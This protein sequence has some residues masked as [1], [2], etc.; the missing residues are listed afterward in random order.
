MIDPD[1][2]YP[3]QF[4]GHV[5]VTLKD[6]SAREA[7]QGHFRG[8]MEQPLSSA[9]LEAKFRANCVYGGWPAAQ[10]E[11]ALAAL[12]AAPSANRPDFSSLRN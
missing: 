9:D 2:P 5:K 10:A 8:G 3:K 7:R 6:G 1:N 11:R 4:S 12:R